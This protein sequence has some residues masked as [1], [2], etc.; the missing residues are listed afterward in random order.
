MSSI[1]DEYEVGYIRT[2]RG[3]HIDTTQTVYWQAFK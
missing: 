3:L 2:D 1:Y